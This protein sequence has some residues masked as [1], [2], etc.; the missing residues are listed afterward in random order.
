ML[1]PLRSE[2]VP[3]Q[4]PDDESLG[5]AHRAWKV[6]D[7]PLMR[8]GRL[9]SVGDGVLVTVPV[10]AAALALGSLS[11]GFGLNHIEI[12]EGF[13]LFRSASIHPGDHNAVVAELG[14][15]EA[16]ESEDRLQSA[17]L[18]RDL[19]V[20]VAQEGLLT[21][22]SDEVDEDF[23]AL[24]YRGGLDQGKGDHHGGECDGELR[25]AD[26]FQDVEN[27]EVSGLVID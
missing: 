5:I 17:L 19:H 16:S 18:G 25:G 1:A 12:E 14:D 4:R 23:P 27:T 3:K 2:R 24:G 6:F 22:W 20:A 9:A 8:A 13:A 26:F 11:W 15:R 21:V 10:G 7:F